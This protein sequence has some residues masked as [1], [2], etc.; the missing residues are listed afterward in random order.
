MK[1]YENA[2]YP[3]PKWD[4]QRDGVRG[5]YMYYPQSNQ[6]AKTAPKPGQE[7]W[8]LV[9]EKIVAVGRASVPSSRT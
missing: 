4:D 1:Y 6:P 8:S 2:K 5:N 9:A 3:W 7:E